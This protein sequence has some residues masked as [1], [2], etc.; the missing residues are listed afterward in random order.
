MRKKE[1]FSYFLRIYFSTIL[2]FLESFI[3]L[4]FDFVHWPPGF[5]IFLDYFGI[6]LGLVGL[7]CLGWSFWIAVQLE[8]KKKKKEC[9][10]NER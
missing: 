3:F 5:N 1:R 8:K 7:A 10:M 4:F 2:L 9:E 6:F